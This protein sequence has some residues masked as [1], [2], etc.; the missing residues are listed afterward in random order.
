MRTAVPAGVVLLALALLPS[1]TGGGSTGTSPGNGLAQ[2]PPEVHVLGATAT[3]EGRH[4]AVLTFAA[5]NAGTDTDTLT[6]VECSCGGTATILQGGT[7]PVDG[8]DIAPDENHL[9]GPHGDLVRLDD[10]AIPLKAGEFVSLT[11]TFTNAGE[12]R[13]DAEITPAEG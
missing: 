8:I 7:A 13:A 9:F 6:G 1:C 12:V 5:H 10:V 11:L 2:M 3:P 4:G